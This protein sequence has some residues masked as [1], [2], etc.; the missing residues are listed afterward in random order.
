MTETDSEVKPATV[1]DESDVSNEQRLDNS[2]S[3]EHLYKRLGVWNSD[4]YDGRRI[5]KTRQRTADRLDVFDAVSSQLE[6]TNYQ[7]N[8]AG[9]S[10]DN[11]PESYKISHPAS[12]VALC[13]C[14]LIANEDGR[15]YHPNHLNP[16][17]DSSLFG[18]VAENMG[19]SYNEVYKCWSKLS[20]EV[21]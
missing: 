7:T 8:E 19:F 1:F 16:S 12:L 9:R 10:F 18:R 17:N 21:R 13:V 3:K 11:L 5:S 15:G 4:S 2:E 14:G 6:L 20:T